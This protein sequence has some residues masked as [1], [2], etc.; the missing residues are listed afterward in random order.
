LNESQAY[1]FKVAAHS[2]KDKSSA[3]AGG[4]TTGPFPL[5]SPQL[6]WPKDSS[7]EM[8]TVVTFKWNP[9][10]LN[11]LYRIR[12]STREDFSE[13]SLDTS[14][15]VVPVFAVTGLREKTAYFWQVMAINGKKN[16]PWSKQFVFIT[17]GAQ[18]ASDAIR[19]SIP[20]LERNWTA[21]ALKALSRG[22][23][24]ESIDA[25]EKISPKND[26]LCIRIA[27]KCINV[28][29]SKGAKRILAIA[30]QSDMFAEVLRARILMS[31]NQCADAV[32]K[33][34]AGLKLQ[35][36]F[37]VQSVQGDALYFK[38]KAFSC[39][40]LQNKA[41]FREKALDAWRDVWKMYKSD[42]TNPRFKEATAASS[43]IGND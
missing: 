32:V 16:S 18:I 2:S 21:I 23:L 34:D 15:I 19:D 4:F 26:T 38:A 31:E 9:D 39:L 40:W 22:R 12:L 42:A 27:E 13:T 14:G 24:G 30:P 3:T 25:A 10:S 33:L 41:Q 43:L 11:R 35:T 1:Y 37:N 36:R 17:A 6:L 8:P 29:D 20:P 5:Q 28:K 7:L